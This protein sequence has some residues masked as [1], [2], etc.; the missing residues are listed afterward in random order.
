MALVSGLAGFVRALWRD[1]RRGMALVSALSLVLLVTEGVG[2]LLLVP[3]LRAVGVGAPA[4]EGGVVER[5]IAARHVPFTLPAMLMLVVALVSLRAAAQWWYAV[6]QGA[7]EARVVSQLRTRLF[8]AVVEMPWARFTGERPAALMHALGPQ[9]DDVHSALILVLQGLSLLATIL[10]GALAAFVLSPPLLG[11]VVVLG[12][13][14]FVLARALRAPGRAEGDALLR[15]A[16]GVFAR[17]GEL[18]GGMK[19][20]HAHD[21][22][23][24]AVATVRRET[25][26][27]SAL[28]RR[29]AARRAAVGFALAVVAVM[30][31]GVLVYAATAWMHV[32]VAP[33]LVLLALYARL[34]PRVSELQV[35]SSHLQQ[36]LASYASVEAL[37]R[38][39]EGAASHDVGAANGGAASAAGEPHPHTAPPAVALRRV[40]FGYD[41]GGEVLHELTLDL[42]PGAI[43]AL[44]G[45][46]GAGKT[47][48]ADLVLGLLSPTT[49]DVLVNGQ[50]LTALPR[51]DWRASIG[52]LAQDPM[53]MHG[54]I[55]ANLLLA[56]PD[57]TEAQLRHALAAAACDFVR[58]LDAP[59]GD[60]GVQLSGGERQ[61]LAL[62]RALLRDPRLLVLDE[63]TSALDADTER[64][65]LQTVAALRGKCTVLIITHRA[66]P[67]AIA[68]RILEI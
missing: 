5:V 18:L 29:V 57:A 56:R 49:G 26:E 45:D 16:E 1:H 44:V 39:C 19:M 63:A 37:L 59:I 21:A 60:R 66:G 4:A 2:L 48:V 27:W 67:R 68:D 6:E 28:M 17:L 53:L 10:A 54:S 55:R 3:V 31:L 36:A 51:R 9:V 12:A 24:V 50:P 64:R 61:R 20:V 46:S 33:L 41:G 47:T 58:D 23:A 43:T 30:V 34:V 15:S 14:M 32:G 25:E 52:Y 22:D 65:V 38:R 42:A 8:A 40:S 13:L 35:I 62:A 7:L 11:V